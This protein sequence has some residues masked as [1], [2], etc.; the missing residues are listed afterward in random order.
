MITN[1]GSTHIMILIFYDDG[2]LLLLL[3]SRIAH[4][5]PWDPRILVNGRFLKGA[6]VFESGKRIRQWALGIL[7]SYLYYVDNFNVIGGHLGND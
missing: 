6:L 3:M 7:L 4:K 1:L 2:F 5:I